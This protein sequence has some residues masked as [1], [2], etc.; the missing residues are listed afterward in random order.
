MLRD[1][2]QPFARAKPRVVWV[3]VLVQVALALTAWQV[4]RGGIVP[5]P[6]RVAARVLE[7]WG[8]ELFIDNFLTTLSLTIKGMAISIGIALL[9]AYS[10][11][12]ELFKPLAQL[13]VKL[14][15]LTLTGLIFVF[16]LLTGGS[17][18]ALKL[19]LIIFGIVPF[20]VNSLLTI[21]AD[22]PREEKDLCRTLR[23]GPWR[24]LLE[25]VVIGR[26]DHVL[27]V[28]RS[29][30]AIAWMMITMVEGV[31]MSEGGLGTLMIKS[32]K[33][34]DLA[35][36]LAI[37]LN[38]LAIGFAFDILLGRARTWFFPYSRK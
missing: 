25:S 10:S 23:M 22:I 19:T 27:E 31:C 20:F 24:T 30:F 1:L 18:S 36:V 17:G 38:I 3:L 21:I 9:V 32:N 12:V 28:V 6:G 5:G 8:T 15:Y 16:L 11:T 35:T 34:I 14:R 26:A 33:Y 2:I 13:V 4:S 7:L 37:L 29:N